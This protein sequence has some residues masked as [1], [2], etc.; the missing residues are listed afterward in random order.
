MLEEENAKNDK[1]ITFKASKDTSDSD[2]SENE[3]KYT[4]ILRK[5]RNLIMKKKKGFKKQDLSK[6]DK[7]ICY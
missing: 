4:I 2:S 1:S 5:V 7:M 3:D 6:T